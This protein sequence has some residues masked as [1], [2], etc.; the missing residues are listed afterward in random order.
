MTDVAMIG[1]GQMGGP[2]ADNVVRAGHATRVFDISA[3]A[4]E[5]RV[6]LGATAASSPAAAASGCTVVGI[7]VFDDAQVEAVVCGDDGVLETLEPGAVIMV[8]T[9]A[10]LD[11][12]RRVSDAAV[13]K[14]VHLIDAGISGG[15]TGAVA[16]TL[17]LMVGGSDVAVELAR[18]VLDSFAKEVVH[19]GPLGAGMALKLARNA[20]GYALMAA[21]HEAMKLAQSAGV[22]AKA[23]EHVLRETALLDQG[24]SPFLFGG[25]D[26]LPAGDH[27]MRSMMEHLARL[28]DKDLEHAQNLAA[29][30]GVVAP[31][32]DATRD[33]FA[34][35]ARL[36]DD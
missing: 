30:L 22:D 4:V 35:V 3:A 1:L 36:G 6:A 2:M 12:I 5:S 16:G 9:T 7:V 11:T 34:S 24:L 27:P 33:E 28:G 17:M 18:P 25:P 21:V 8:H 15:E 14:G 29:E 31:V 19:A 32:F 23:L 26:P 10:T 20:T 13:A